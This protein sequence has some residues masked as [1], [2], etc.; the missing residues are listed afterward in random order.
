LAGHIGVYSHN[1]FENLGDDHL[2]GQSFYIGAP[3]A[4]VSEPVSDGFPFFRGEL[5][6]TQ[7]ITLADRHV[8]LALLGDGQHFVSLDK[9]IKTML[10][11]GL[12]LQMK[13]KE[14][15]RGGLA[16]SIVEC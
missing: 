15:S 3:P 14:T 9:V 12:D 2:L 16:V 1:A 10:E 4:K 6:L 13:Y 8:R 11:T 7:K 5:T